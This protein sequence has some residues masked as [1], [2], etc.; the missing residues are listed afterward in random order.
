MYTMADLTR[1][2]AEV[3]EGLIAQRARMNRDWIVQ[4]I[5]A[6]HDDV[7]GED[8]EFYRCASRKTV[9]AQVRQQINRFDVRAEL[10]PDRQ[11][12]LD[13]FERLQRYYAFEERGV[14]VAVPVEDMSDAQ[15]EAKEV[16]LMAMGAGCYQHADEIRRYRDQR[17][18]AA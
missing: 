8:A 4:M 3:M 13:G 17:R 12:V 10:T 5:L 15:L 2:I 18:S 7:A 14:Q 6:R 1:E 9:E 16:E 11:M